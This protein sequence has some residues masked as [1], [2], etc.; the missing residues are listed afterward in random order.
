MDP[1]GTPIIMLALAVAGHA[2]LTHFKGP[3]E[4]NSETARRLDDLEDAHHAL[5]KDYT[6]FQERV[7]AEL[8]NLADALNRL[9]IAL[10]QS[11]LSV[12][13]EHRVLKRRNE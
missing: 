9:A 1:I 2:M 5:D 3:K 13:G 11:H 4:T 6:G 12:S 10:N 8:H 7:L